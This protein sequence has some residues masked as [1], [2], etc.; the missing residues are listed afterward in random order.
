MPD[1]SFHLYLSL[2]AFWLIIF[3]YFLVIQRKLSKLEK[4]YND[5]E[6]RIK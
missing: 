5:L 6:L 3:L 1:T 4:S 2:I